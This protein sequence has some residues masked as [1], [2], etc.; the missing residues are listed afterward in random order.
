MKSYKHR[1]IARVQHSSYGFR[2][3]LIDRQTNFL[4]KSA[5][6]NS[7]NMASYKKEAVEL[8]VAHIEDMSY[9]E[10]VKKYAET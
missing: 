2:I 4:M 3:T 10:E 6:Y 1:Y 8:S 7:N 9:L 5:E